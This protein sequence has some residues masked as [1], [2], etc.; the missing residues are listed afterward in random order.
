LVPLTMAECAAK[1]VGY[2]ERIA[3]IGNVNVISDI[4]TATM[5]AIGAG[6]G[7]SWMVRTNLRAMKDPA[8]I[9]ELSERLQEALEAIEA[10]RQYVVSTVGARA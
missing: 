10:G 4:A 5:M 8:R 3:T 9:N 7:A 6:T 2:C 1:L